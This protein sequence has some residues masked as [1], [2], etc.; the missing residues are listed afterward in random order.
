[1]LE[2]TKQAIYE[3][4]ARECRNAGRAISTNDILSAIRVEHRISKETLL[5]GLRE[6]KGEGALRN[7]EV[8]NKNLWWTPDIDPH[9]PERH[10]VKIIN[11]LKEIIS[12]TG[13]PAPI[14][15]IARGAGLDEN[16]VRYYL[17]YGRCEGVHEIKVAN[18]K[19]LF[20]LSEDAHIVEKPKPEPIVKEELLKAMSNT[21]IGDRV[22][23]DYHQPR[24]GNKRVRHIKRELI[25]SR[26][27]PRLCIFTSG[28]SVRWSEMV[29]YYRSGKKQA[30]EIAL[31]RR[32][33]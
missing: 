8:S 25:V 11:A 23:V 18:N 2:E 13:N 27:T 14:I 31:A 12:K 10:E 5:R 1:M 4:T 32:A 6:L 17:R 24:D 20:S 3:T 26:K 21:G 33:N 22:T 9:L 19:F 28:D 15:D 16:T 30:V 7:Y 29:M